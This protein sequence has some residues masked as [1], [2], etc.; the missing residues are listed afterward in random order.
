MSFNCGIVGLP[1]VGKSTIFNALSRTQAAQAENY[2]FCTIDPNTAMVEVPE[3]RLAVL[4]G[5]V[6]T[7]R[8]VP[9]QMELVDIAGLVKGANEGA[10]KGNAFLANIRSVDAILHVVRCFADDNVVHVDGSVDPVR[11]IEVIDLELI[12]KDAETVRKLLER[13]RKRRADP[14]ARAVVPV[15]ER[16]LA[17]FDECLPVRRLDLT[18][19]EARVL[20]E[21]QLLTA[22]P[23]LYV[24]NIGEEDLTTGGNPWSRMVAAHAAA[25]GSRS[26]EICGTI[27][28]ELAR[29]DEAERGEFMDDLGIGE[30]GLD[31]LIRAGY[32]LMGLS[33]FFTAGEMEARAWQIVSGWTAPQAAGVIHS[34]FERGF[35][36]A[37]V[38][39]YDDF[40]AC[41]GERGCREAG[42]LRAEGKEYVVREGDVIHFLAN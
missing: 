1:N 10:G 35:I 3:P 27:E 36:R 40:V 13:T 28:Q 2:P 24:C 33:T 17:G 15:L 12:C 16:V 4:A 30:P 26:L 34:D 20:H 42:K 37:E 29:L 8:L 31:Q 5:I 6:G 21:L 23:M 39:A 25:T 32:E 11:D 9:V 22:K 41:G 38:A 7:S 18:V 14:E 19:E